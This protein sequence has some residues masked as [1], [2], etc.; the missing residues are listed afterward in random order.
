MTR[1]KPRVLLAAGMV[2]TFAF[3][4]YARRGDLATFDWSIDPGALC[5]AVALLAVP[6]LVQAATFVVAL[7]RVGGDGPWRDVL[8]VWARSWLLRY[9]PSGAVGFAYRVGAR[10]R[11]G[12]TTPQVLTATAYEQLAAIAGG[13]LA[14]PVGFAVAGLAPPAVAL[15]GA[16]G[17]V[18]ALVALRPAWLGGFVRRRL[19]A[20]GI[21]AAAP[22]RGRTV[23][24]LVAVHAAGWTATAIGLG[25]VADGVGAGGAPVGVLLG[26]AALSWLAGVLVPLAPGGL[27]VRD[28]ALAV[29]ITGACAGA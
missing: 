28:A 3:A 9:E 8:R 25:L 1:F 7:R 29:T 19:E 18:L 13:A 24:A 27:G 6:G 21:E 22:L 12:A 20:R 23:A 10:E 2:A 26:A 11:L 17:A 14:A 16:A 5:A 4:L 15:V